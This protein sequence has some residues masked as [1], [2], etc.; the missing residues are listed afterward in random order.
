[1]NEAKQLISNLDT[2]L[3]SSRCHYEAILLFNKIV[4]GRRYLKVRVRHLWILEYFIFIIIIIIIIIIV[5]IMIIWKF[6]YLCS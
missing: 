1:M 5:I 2:N 4:L 3:E 6:I